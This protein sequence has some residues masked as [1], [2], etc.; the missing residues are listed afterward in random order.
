MGP[1]A[2]HAEGRGKNLTAGRVLG[3]K[4]MA[5]NTIPTDTLAEAKGVPPKVCAIRE[6]KELIGI[7]M[8]AV[9]SKKPHV[10]EQQ[11]EK[12]SPAV[13][14]KQ[15]AAKQSRELN[16]G[17]Q[18]KPNR[19]RDVNLRQNRELDVERPLNFLTRG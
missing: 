16:L 14:K 3:T 12:R 18:L 10:L 13:L 7:E 15:F 19:E 17:R 4:S 11:K 9:I 6:K 8:K 2:L 5:I 1:A